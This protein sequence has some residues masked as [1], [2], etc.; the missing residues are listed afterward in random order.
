MDADGHFARFA[1]ELRLEG[2]RLESAS[3][4]VT[5][6]VDSLDTG[7]GMRDR[8]LRSEDFFDA[9]RHPR[10]TLVLTGARRD[11][12]R[13]VASGDLTIRGV[14]RPLAVPLTVTVGPGTLRAAGEFTLNRREFGVAYQSRLNPVR[15]EVRV[16]IE[17][18][19]QAR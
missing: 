8:H 12:P 11:G 14:T 13:V 15:D 3:G 16:S 19:F 6:E 4:R 17:L 9:A 2:D 1:G 18:T 7:S 5:V 10:A